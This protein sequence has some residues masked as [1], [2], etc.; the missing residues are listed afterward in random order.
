MLSFCKVAME[1][2]RLLWRHSN[3][4][5]YIVQNIVQKYVVHSDVEGYTTPNGGTI[6]AALAV[7]GLKPDITV[8]DVEKKLFEI[9][10]LS[11]PFEDCIMARHRYKA[12]HYAHF[13]TKLPSLHSKSGQE[14]S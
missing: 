4:V 3:I 11:V 5:K 1:L 10:E 7:T 13:S 14:D 8:M 12:N 6:P 9:L 2:G